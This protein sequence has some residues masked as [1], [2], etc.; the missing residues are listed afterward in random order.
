M[1]HRPSHPGGGCVM[2]ALVA[3]LRRARTVRPLLWWVLALLVYVVAPVPQGWVLL[4]IMGLGVAL[5]ITMARLRDGHRGIGETAGR[6]WDIA[7]RLAGAVEDR[8]RYGDPE[9]H[10]PLYA[11]PQ[12]CGQVPPGHPFHE[13]VSGPAVVY[14]PGALLSGLVAVLAAEG[15]PTD[16]A[17]A[18]PAVAAL[19]AGLGIAPQPGVPAPTALGLVQALQVGPPRRVRVL[20]SAL[21]ASVMRVMLTHD[22]VLP[23]QITT[24]VAESLTVHTAQIL[25]ALGI[26][27]GDAGSLTDWPVIA[28]I[29]DAASLPVPYEPWNR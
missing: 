5:T 21:V 29:V 25:M 6:M 16:A 11:P 22:G 14:D 10:A 8:I 9:D 20:S 15:L 17:A 27:P 1:H 7:E 18:L 13:P 26:Q 24:D 2:L 3:L 28:Q 19:L 12:P 23:E 4:L